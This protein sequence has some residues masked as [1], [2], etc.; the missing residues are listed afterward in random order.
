M[1]K[2]VYCMGQDVLNKVK[3]YRMTENKPHDLS[4][5]FGEGRNKNNELV[6]QPRSQFAKR[7][8]S[9]ESQIVTV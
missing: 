7:M 5:S 1:V 6:E 4:V 8:A 2:T 3:Q 9:T